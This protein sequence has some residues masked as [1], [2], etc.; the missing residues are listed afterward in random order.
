MRLAT[1][2]IVCCLAVLLVAAPAQGAATRAEYVAQV[3]PI[4]QAAAPELKRSLAAVRE[5]SPARIEQLDPKEGLKRVARSFG[6]ALGRTNKVLTAMT[7]R[8]ATVPAAPGDELTVADWIL[9]QRS[10]ED[11]LGRAARAGKRGKFFRMFPLLQGYEEAVAALR[12]S[13]RGF[14]FRHC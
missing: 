6:K 1:P 7:T 8:I 4:C 3:D 14:G 13:V 11:L 9:N 2:L 5:P 10:A 12:A